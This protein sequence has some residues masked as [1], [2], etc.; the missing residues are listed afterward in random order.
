MYQHATCRYK[1]FVPLNSVVL[2]QASLVKQEKRKAWINCQLSSVVVSDD[3]NARSAGCGV[4][5][6]TVS[7]VHTLGESLF[8]QAQQFRGPTYDTLVSLM[9][10]ESGID[11]ATVLKLIEQQ[12]V[13]LRKQRQAA[14]ARKAKL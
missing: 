11:K 4:A 8:Y 5:G 13:H 9:G 14:A 10:K 12:R 7:Q 6:V 3:S 2:V 1:N